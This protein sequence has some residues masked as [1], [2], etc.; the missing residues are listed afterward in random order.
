MT[1]EEGF[2]EIEDVPEL[3]VIPRPRNVV[4]GQDVVEKVFKN[5]ENDFLTVLGIARRARQILEDYPEYEEALEDETATTLALNEFLADGF[6][7]SVRNRKTKTA[8]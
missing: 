5:S 4:P 7:I 1:D 2:E 3:E 6:E 8:K